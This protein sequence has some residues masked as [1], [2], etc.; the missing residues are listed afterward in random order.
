VKKGE[1]GRKKRRGESPDLQSKTAGSTARRKSKERVA[2]QKEGKEEKGF[3]LITL[4]SNQSGAAE[5]EKG[6]GK[7]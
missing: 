5:G 1:G 6:P 7:K 2:R 3:R 4:S